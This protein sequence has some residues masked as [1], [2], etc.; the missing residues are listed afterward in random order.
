MGGRSSVDLDTSYAYSDSYYD[1]PLLSIVGHPLAVN[2][3]PRMLG[4][5]TL[6]RW[7]VVYL[8]V[9]AGVPKFA[10]LEPQRV[11]LMLAQPQLFPWV[12]F[13]IDGIE[14][15]PSTARQIL[16]ANHRC[17]FD[18]LAI[19]FVLADGA[20][21]C[22][23]SARRRCSTHPWSGDVVTAL[24]GIRVDRGTGSDEPLRAAEMAL[25]AG[26]LVAI[27]PQGTIPRGPAFFE[28]ELKGR[29][30]AAKLA[31]GAGVPVIPIGLWGTEEVW[32]RSSK[33]PD[34]TN[35]LSPPTVQIRVGEPVELPGDDLDE[36]TAT[37]MAAIA[38]LL[39]PEASQPHTPTRDELARTY[40]GGVIP[41]EDDADHESHRRPG[42][43]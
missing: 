29:W 38:D 22:G 33:L 4:V 37:I 14:N 2:P 19:G 31:T 32:P 26:E 35:V 12:R 30:G 36:D 9:P 21:P 15:I 28:P 41:D 1:V 5:A 8:D 18:P 16:V 6:R 3:D 40:P 20:G 39:P 13:D 25:A 7:P 43:D 23:S 34:V 27:M 24:G 10:G 17:Y 42:T 11:L